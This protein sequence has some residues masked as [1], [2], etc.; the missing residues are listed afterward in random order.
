MRQSGREYTGPVS[1]AHRP[2]LSLLAPAVALAALA[3]RPVYTVQAPAPAACPEP[4]QAAAP[5][6]AAPADAKP[7]AADDLPTYLAAH[8]TKREVRIPMRDGVHLHTA[9]YTPKDTSKPHPILLRRTPYGCAPYGEDKFPGRLGPSPP[10]VRAGYIFVDQDVRGAFMSE[11]EFVNMRPHLAQ[12]SGLKDIDESTDTHDTIAWLLA[13]VPGNNGKVGMYGISY[14]GFY[15]AA[16]MID[17]H[18]ALVAVSP[19]API[20]DW[21]YDDFHHHGAFFLPHTFNFFASFGK[22]RPQPRSEWPPRFEHGTPD[23]YQ[24]FLDIGPLKN[25]QARHLKGEIAFWNELVRHPDYDDFW[26]QRDLLPHLKNVAPAVMTVGGWY[27]AEDLYGPLSIYRTVETQGSARYNVLVMGPWSHGGWSRTDGERLG[28]IGFGAKTSHEYQ[29][30]IELPFFEHFLKGEGAPPQGEAFVFDTGAMQWRTFDV[31]PPPARPKDMFAG[32]GGALVEQ[33]PEGRASSDAFDS[34]PARPVPF[35]QDIAIGMTKEYMTEDQRFA[36]RRPD[37]LV[38]QTP[39]LAADL[40]IAGPIDAELWVSTTGTDAD[41]VVKLIDVLPPDTP[42]PPDLRR[43][44]KLG[45]YQRM[46]RSEVVRGR[47]RDSRERP[48]PFVPNRPTRVRVPLQDVLHTFKQ[49]HRIMIHVQSTWFPLVD[50]N[51]QT[52]VPNIFEADEGDF[53]KATHRVHRAGAHRSKIV[54]PV[55]TDSPPPQ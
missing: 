21:W 35:T 38:Y 54:L 37:V 17:P 19:Q 25:L 2:R 12:K 23:G 55:L 26:K 29:Q 3:C 30:R 28:D 50:R 20:A 27:D 52:F 9:I 24:F 47:Y 51:P 53:K 41:W 7:P 32:P 4:V 48:A 8:Y 16:G 5:A 43:G 45:G 22:P 39:P 11:G 31:W 13:N 1:V 33:P 10:F 42:D 15:A 6:P 18:P 36:A 14:P 44:V 49:G 46:V 34:D 40:T